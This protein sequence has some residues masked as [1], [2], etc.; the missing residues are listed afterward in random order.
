MLIIRR[1][2]IHSSRYYHTH[3]GWSSHRGSPERFKDKL[4]DV[5]FEKHSVGGHQPN[6]LFK[7]N[8]ATVVDVD[9]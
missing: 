6:E 2:V 9:H 1:Q 4:R 8:T 5:S 3:I 7:I